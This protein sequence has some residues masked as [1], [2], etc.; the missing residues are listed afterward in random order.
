MLVLLTD[1]PLQHTIHLVDI[2]RNLRLDVLWVVQLVRDHVSIAL[3][4]VDLFRAPGVHAQALDL[5][6]MR[7]KFP[8]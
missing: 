6:D 3:H 1:V 4:A 5:A 7:S 2:N 8:V